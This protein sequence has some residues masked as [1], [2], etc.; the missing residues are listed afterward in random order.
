MTRLGEAV[1]D[2]EVGAGQFEGM[3]AERQLLYPHLLDVLGRPAVAGR[4]GKVRTIVSEH[5]VDPVRHGCGQVPQEVAGNPAGGLLVQFD[6]RELG[7]PVDRYQQVELALLGPHLGQIDVEVAD[8]VLLELLSGR[9][10]AIDLG[11]PADTVAL[12]ASV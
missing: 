9:L 1:L 2:I 5:R 6:E 7:R 12:E 11:Q 10:V 4:V 8:R 3:A